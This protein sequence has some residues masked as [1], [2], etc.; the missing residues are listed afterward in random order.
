MVSV[1]H[2]TFSLLTKPNHWLSIVCLVS[3]MCFCR[4]HPCGFLYGRS[5][6]LLSHFRTEPHGGWAGKDGKK[7]WEP[8]EHVHWPLNSSLSG[9]L[10]RFSTGD[11]H[12][13]KSIW[14]NGA[15]DK[16]DGQSHQSEER[17]R[18]DRKSQINIPED[19]NQ[20]KYPWIYTRDGKLSIYR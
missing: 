18:R 4:I 19:V 2:L 6:W 7:R 1:L 3:N 12:I 20:W 10:F 8:L 13:V 11:N 14:R 15:E 16:I 9:Q 17:T 5:L